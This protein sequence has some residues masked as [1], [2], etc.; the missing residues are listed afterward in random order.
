ML[1]YTHSNPHKYTLVYIAQKHPTIPSFEARIDAS[2][3]PFSIFSMRPT[4]SAIISAKVIELYTNI[5]NLTV[6]S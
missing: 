6:F 1:P 5:S 3:F 2:L 4:H